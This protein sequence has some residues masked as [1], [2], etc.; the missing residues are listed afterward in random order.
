[1]Q[2]VPSVGTLLFEKS[3]P[4][5]T[6]KSIDLIEHKFGKLNYIQEKTKEEDKIIDHYLEE[7]RR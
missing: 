7:V 3:N 4:F 6:Y 5:R 1:L 2:Q